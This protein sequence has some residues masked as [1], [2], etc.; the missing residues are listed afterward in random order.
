[1]TSFYLSFL[2]SPWL[3][4]L[5]PAAVALTLIPYFRL[6]KRYRRTRNRIISITMHL[7]VSVLCISVLAGMQFVYETPN[8]DNEMVVIVDMSDSTSDFDKS[9]DDFLDELVS[10]SVL[11]NCK[12]GLVAFG[13][14]QKVIS[15]LTTDISSLK[16]DYNTFKENISDL[17]TDA[18][19][20]AAAFRTA[21][22]MIKNPGSGKIVLISD[23]VQ[24]DENALSVIRTLTAKGIKIDVIQPTANF[25]YDDLSEVQVCDVTLPQDNIDLNSSTTINV[26]IKSKTDNVSASLQLYDLY[27][28]A[29]ATAASV[30]AYTQ[31][32]ILLNK[33]EQNISITYSF[34]NEPFHEIRVVVSTGR[35]VDEETTKNNE[36]STYVLIEK[37]NKVLIIDGFK[38]A[39]ANL[40]SLLK[41]DNE[42]VEA[43][44][45]A[46]QYE[47][48][49]VV[50]RSVEYAEQIDNLTAY[51]QVI[52]NNV[53]NSDLPDGDIEKIEEYVKVYG[54]GLLTVGGNDEKGDVHVYDRNDLGKADDSTYQD[55][56]PINAIDYTPSMGVAFILD[57]SGSMS[58]ALP[59][60][61][62]ALESVARYTLTDRDY[63]AIFTL[64]T[65][66][67]QVL[68]L[69]PRTNWNTILKA[70]YSIDGTGGTVA[71]N[72]I[73]RAGQA[74][75]NAPVESKHI[76]MLTDGMFGD[77]KV[78]GKEAPFI[79]E[80]RNNYQKWGIKLSV[81]GIGMNYGDSYYNDCVTMTEAAGGKVHITTDYKD[82]GK[83]IKDA[84][85]VESVGARKETEYTPTINK[86][87]DPI[88]KDMFKKS[89]TDASSTATNEDGET[90][91]G[92]SS[93]GI[94]DF[95][96]KAFYGGRVK[97]NATLA[98]VGPDMVP[99]YAYWQYGKGRVGSF[100]CDLKGTSDS[101]SEGL[102]ASDIGK[103]LIFGIVREL[104]P[105]TR[106][107][108]GE[109]SCDLTE[110]NYLNTL[111][112]YRTAEQGD[113]VDVTVT[114]V[115][116]STF[117]EVSLSKASEDNGFG[118]YVITP[119]SAE[120][121]YSKA[122]FVVRTAGVYKITVK[123]TA[124]DGTTKKTEL[125]KTFSY[126]EE[127][128]KFPEDDSVGKT[129]MTNIAARADGNYIDTI[130]GL[131][132]IYENFDPVIRHVY[133]PRYL[134]II[135]SIVA[136][137]IDI[138]VRK[139]KFKW[140]HELIREAKEKK[141]QEKQ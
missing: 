67:G 114:K 62:A 118:V 123:V 139:F 39:S 141:E 6:A 130:A 18:T 47:V 48:T 42:K 2:V 25:E 78:D 91:G 53:S 111:N 10:D 131:N 27:S 74:L 55:M 22:N 33:G 124:S 23:G 70:I 125:Y 76:I 60:A 129:L 75:A 86:I 110:E 115:N 3:M 45:N 56:L 106:L 8:N 107:V 16:S 132:G 121:L 99:V 11:Y 24:T 93:S 97:S 66:Y 95:K 17:D 44:E 37:F 127:Y 135:I 1:M 109:V 49:T 98:V 80:A 63:M 32:G 4:L 105:D 133:D 96:L 138:A 36:F 83:T 108:A 65:T 31:D 35:T 134:F 43:L 136:F 38:D 81:I 122:V 20:I 128:E 9:R 89:T 101:Y 30:P 50:V 68:P 88:F 72:A 100:M 104:M 46:L 103:S 12:V 92:T 58:A 7:I 40:S 102:F 57:V 117:G 59:D 85:K 26:K 126:S 13:F 90:E 113:K 34:K 112:I 19:N 73:F 69:T 82:I 29:P 52:L 94:F 137:L 71:T 5:I 77:E 15:G 54:G 87:T 64:D 21:G 119:L 116:S 79:T 61:R 41:G 51:D 120:N 14:N 28:G 84:I 140:P